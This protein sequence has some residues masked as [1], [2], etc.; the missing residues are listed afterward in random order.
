MAEA[1]SHYRDRRDSKVFNLVNNKNGVSLVEVVIALALMVIMFAMFG[2]IM[3]GTY[4]SNVSLDS[5]KSGREAQV[6]S[7]EFIMG[8]EGEDTQV[9][10]KA[11]IVLDFSNDGVSD[12]LDTANGGLGVIWDG[13]V[14]ISGD[15]SQ[16]NSG[17]YVYAYRGNQI[18]VDTP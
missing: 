16:D 17:K 14:S 8:T 2:M 11:Q 9:V 6:D 13:E 3:A 10:G 1:V 15:Y 12:A 4:K 7:K 5:N 18:H